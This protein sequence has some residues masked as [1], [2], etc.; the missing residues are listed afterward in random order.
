MKSNA[1]NVIEDVLNCVGQM[2][3]SGSVSSQMTSEA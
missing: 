2:F 1:F 3:L